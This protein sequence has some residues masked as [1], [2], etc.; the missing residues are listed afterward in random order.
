MIELLR[1]SPYVV[2]YLFAL[3]YLIY[4]ALFVLGGVNIVLARTGTARLIGL[5]AILL[6]LAGLFGVTGA[7]LHRV[8]VDLKFTLAPILRP[9]GGMGWIGVCAAA[10]SL[11]GALGQRWNSAG[12]VLPILCAIA[13]YVSWTVAY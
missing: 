8:F 3:N 4:P 1:P 10:I 11:C 12:S 9:L 13:M 6:T 5:I 2:T 7:S